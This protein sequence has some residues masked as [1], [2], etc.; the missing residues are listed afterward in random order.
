MEEI[1]FAMYFSW[2]LTHLSS[3]MMRNI[4]YS[5]YLKKK[6]MWWNLTWWQAN[7]LPLSHRGFHFNA[8]RTEVQSVAEMKMMKKKKFMMMMMM[9][10]GGRGGGGGCSSTVDL[11]CFQN[12]VETWRGISTSKVFSAL[13]LSLFLFI[14]LFSWSIHR[15]A[16]SHKPNAG[17]EAG[18]LFQ[19]PTKQWGR[20]WSWQWSQWTVSAYK[21]RFLWLQK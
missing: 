17:A 7:V 5:F 19:R 2:I 15:D 9:K 11:W 18:G 8:I 10:G 1:I 4:W 3:R 14:Y 20:L 6:K 21:S 13:F 16:R 12:I